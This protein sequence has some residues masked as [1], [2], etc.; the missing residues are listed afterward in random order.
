[1]EDGA[2][3]ESAKEMTPPSIF[4][5]R[6]GLLSIIAAALLVMLALAEPSPTKT[7]RVHSA[8]RPLERTYKL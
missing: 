3:T 2:R 5:F 6:V 1:M 8:F 7:M 4:W